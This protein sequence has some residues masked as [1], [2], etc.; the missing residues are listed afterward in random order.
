VARRC[1]CWSAG[2]RARSATRV[3]ATMNRPSESV[4]VIRVA[5]SDGSTDAIVGATERSDR[6]RCL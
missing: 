1:R 3:H 4:P 5:V 6:L 2:A